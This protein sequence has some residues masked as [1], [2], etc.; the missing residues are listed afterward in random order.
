MFPVWVYSKVI[1]F[2][3]G[4]EGY[5]FD[6]TSPDDVLWQAFKASGIIMSS[7]GVED[8]THF[9]FDIPDRQ[10]D[11]WT[12]GWMDETE[13]KAEAEPCII[14]NTA[15]QI[16]SVIERQPQKDQVQQDSS[17]ITNVTVKD[18]WFSLP[19]LAAFR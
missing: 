5:S 9:V 13:L 19:S 7:A 2:K 15:A 8:T 3:D 18:F 12:D 4:L 11:G 16:V 14:Q 1:K 6:L 10:T 17:H